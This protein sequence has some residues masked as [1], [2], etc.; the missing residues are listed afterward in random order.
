MLG[1]DGIERNWNGTNKDEKSQ[2]SSE[3]QGEGVAFGQ[4][5]DLGF[6]YCRHNLSNF[7]V[8]DPTSIAATEC[9]RRSHNGIIID[10]PLRPA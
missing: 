2:K 4:S 10:A 3:P 5:G 8:A 7:A 6:S 1:P 9:D